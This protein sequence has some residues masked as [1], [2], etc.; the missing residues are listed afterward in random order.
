MNALANVSA[1]PDPLLGDVVVELRQAMKWSQKLL[2]GHSGVA[3]SMIRK[4][5]AGGDGS[6]QALEALARVFK[7]PEDSLAL[8]SPG[9]TLP[10]VRVDQGEYG[11][12]LPG[13]IGAWTWHELPWERDRWAQ[14]FVAD[15]PDGARFGE[16][17]EVFGRTGEW[18]REECEKALAKLRESGE[19]DRVRELLTR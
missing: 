8:L 19:L 15:H 10:R 11:R 12:T 1:T 18:A 3:W 5:E 2:A 6:P 16:I 14:K 7:V 4:I 9:R 13:E 17:G